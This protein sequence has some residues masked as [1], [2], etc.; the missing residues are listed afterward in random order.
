MDNKKIGKAAEDRVIEVMQKRGYRLLAR[1]YYVHLAGELDA[2]M[3]KGDNIYVIEVKS[4]YKG[5]NSD[6]DPSLA[7]DRRKRN[8][9]LKATRVFVHKNGLYDKNIIFLVGLVTHSR[10]GFIHNVEITEF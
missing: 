7:I 8:N 2:V 10:S 4:R 9:M 1:N 5:N 3:E 6:Y